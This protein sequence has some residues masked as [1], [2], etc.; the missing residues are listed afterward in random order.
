[1]SF[2][3]CW[4]SARPPRPGPKSPTTTTASSWTTAWNTTPARRP[5]SSCTPSSGSPA[6]PPDHQARPRFPR[7]G[8]MATRMR[9]PRQLSQTWLG[10][11]PRPPRRQERSRDL[12][13]KRGIRHNFGQDRRTSQLTLALND[14]DHTATSLHELSPPSF[15]VEVAS[16]TTKC[17][18]VPLDVALPLIAPWVQYF[19]SATG[20]PQRGF[21]FH[22][23]I[24]PC[25]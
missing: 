18:P 19:T 10:L 4:P 11:G 16:T 20:K 9:R 21:P 8:Q 17:P 22:E 14:R 5:R 12:V 25:G 2:R 23:W 7:A 24:R 3:G 6:A 15:Q 1:M 13:R